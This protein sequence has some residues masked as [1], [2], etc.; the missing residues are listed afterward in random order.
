MFK[1][2]TIFACL[3]FFV[4]TTVFA[5]DFWQPVQSPPGS[6][7]YSLARD[8]SGN[9]YAGTGRGEI[10]YST[11]NGDSWEC[12]FKLGYITDIQVHPN[13]TVYY[14]CTK[15]GLCKF[16]VDKKSWDS[17]Y[18]FSN[19]TELCIAPNGRIF[20]G[21]Q[22]NEGLLYS[23]DFGKTWQKSKFGFSE[24]KYI[25]SISVKNADTLFA[26]TTYEFI[27]ISTDGGKNFTRTDTEKNDNIGDFAFSP[28]ATIWA[29]SSDKIFKST[30]HGENWIIIYKDTVNFPEFRT[31]YSSIDG[32]VYIGGSHLKSYSDETGF[33]IQGLYKSTNEGISWESVFDSTTNRMIYELIDDKFG[34]LIVGTYLEGIYKH[35]SSNNT[36]SQLNFNSKNYVSY[37]TVC[38]NKLYA[39]VSSYLIYTTTNNGED[40]EKINKPNNTFSPLHSIHEAPNGTLYLQGGYMTFLPTPL[41]IPIY[42]STNKGKTWKAQKFSDLS[43][44]TVRVIIS[45]QKYT[46]V[47]N[48]NFEFYKTSDN[49]ETWDSL[50][51]N[52]TMFRGYLT[53]IDDKLFAS[54]AEGILISED[55]GDN[56]K[57]IYQDWASY[58]GMDK[59][60]T[61]YALNNHWN[62]SNKTD[63]FQTGVIKKDLIERYK[64][65]DNIFI[66]KYYNVLFF[67]LK[68]F[69]LFASYDSC[70]SFYP[71]HSGLEIS[72]IKMFAPMNDTALY[73]LSNSNIY[74]GNPNI[75]PEIAKDNPNYLLDIEMIPNTPID[76]IW[77]DSVSCYIIVKDLDGN[78]VKNQTVEM[79]QPFGTI[80]YEQTDQ[81]GELHCLFVVPNGS[82]LY[83]YKFTFNIFHDQKSLAA[84]ASNFINVNFQDSLILTVTPDTIPIFYNIGQTEITDFKGYVKGAT[85]LPKEKVKITLTY[86]ENNYSVSFN[87]NSEG[88]VNLEVLKKSSLN[89][90]IYSVKFYA[91]K[92]KNI[93]S[94]TVIRYYEVRNGLSVDYQ[95]E[96]NST[97]SV[98]PNPA[99]KFVNVLLNKPDGVLH[100]LQIFDMLGGKQLEFEIFDKVQIDVS[101]LSSG[102]YYVL[103]K[104]D[105]NRIVRP[106]IIE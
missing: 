95:H 39:I 18:Y 104:S 66:S 105:S 33:N 45:S 83:D 62:I 32:T 10:F 86:I 77:N 44:H 59:N 76:A 49:G 37:I 47:N 97:L 74:V 73:S 23:D 80:T 100:E 92:D 85:S 64:N 16:S 1:F 79:L 65:F 11:D 99:S 15:Y 51:I 28:N 13:G 70:N 38:N 102:I 6:T 22:N 106:L 56:W 75:I 43:A 84:T 14:L 20:I 40:W 72:S 4:T 96:S 89:P 81:N 61:I 71:M 103:L 35:N 46:F 98:Y 50:T 2:R 82:E 101:A 24:D 25:N 52:N 53:E 3:F 78:R 29:C 87:T 7:V 12:I 90:G 69:G 26:S 41:V 42:I 48:R 60:N 31:I 27:W 8:S 68:D 63:M 94:D 21:N 55:G 5:K 17:V 67:N 9:L 36:W 58:I 57:K 30:N 34:Q 93:P 88:F 19:C 54:N 91:E